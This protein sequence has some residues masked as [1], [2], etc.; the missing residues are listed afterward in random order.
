MLDRPE[1]FEGLNITFN[2]TEDC[3]LACKYCYEVDKRKKDLPID[4]AKKF[5]DIILSD[6]D[7]I[8]AKGT[9]S[10]WILDRGLVLDFIGGDALMRP[11]LVDEILSY[12][13]FTATSMG[14]RWSRNWRA[15]I[16]TNGT[17]FGEPGVKEFCEKYKN[18]LSLGVSIDG[19]PEVH[20]ANRNNSLPR[21]LEHWEWYTNYIGCG[22]VTTKAT[23]NKDSIPYLAESVR[24]M[25]QE[26]GITY[27]D[28]NFIFEDMMLTGYD[29][30][31]LDEQLGWIVDYCYKY[32]DSI[33]CG[34]IAEN[35]IGEP[36]KE[37]DRCWCGSGAMPCLSVNGKIY[38]CF[39]FAPHTM[40]DRAYDFNVGDI[41]EGF[42]RKD[43]FCTVRDQTRGKISPNKCMTCEH[44]S[45]CAWCIGGS[46]AE[47]GEFARQTY[48]CE[49]HKLQSKWAK[50]YQERL[51]K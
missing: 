3:N 27:M 49:V 19:C 11:K 7:P 4:Y 31:M 30:E 32:R 9:D 12:F 10:E 18:N 6:P 51:Q 24:Y 2:V 14:H 17:L 33:Y 26:L 1:D 39:R 20:N 25:H 38:P 16:A 43:R 42:S 37:P 35:R 28:M 50:I 21:I 36:M 46:Y 45:S 13:I 41:W 29:L 48:I 34:L 5:I 23:C 44:E 8:Q 15:S 22:N 40:H 47:T